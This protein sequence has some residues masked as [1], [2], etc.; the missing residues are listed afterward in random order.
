MSG[1]Q[2]SLKTSEDLSVKF[3]LPFYVFRFQIESVF[4]MPYLDGV[5]SVK[6]PEGNKMHIY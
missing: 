2:L 6:Y 5:L 3:T 1:I 4:N